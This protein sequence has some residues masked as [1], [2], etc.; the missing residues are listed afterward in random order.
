MFLTPKPAFLPEPPQ[1]RPY[2]GAI[3][4]ANLLCLFFHLMNPSPAASEAT[5]GY[6]HGGLAMD[7]IGQKGPTSKLHL[8]ML[9][10]LVLLLQLVALGAHVTRIKVK[11]QATAPP[12]VPAAPQPPMPPV[13][14][15]QDLDHEE[16][17]VH[18]SDHDPVD[19][20]LQNL[21]PSVRQEPPDEPPATSIPDEEGNDE[22]D[23][24]LS[25]STQPSSDAHIF[26]A[27][28]SGEI[29]IADL[30]IINLIHTQMREYRNAPSES[31]ATPPGP[32]LSERL[33]RNGLGLRLRIGN[34]I[35]RV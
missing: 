12:A 20:E 3:F 27:F 4:G 7:F 29:M 24:L 21:N 30:D 17:G 34:R 9:D 15:A 1:N 22:R 18:R 33:S 35:L 2:I 14:P 13:Q 26:D 28:N 31:T 23:T 8:S 5:R 10:M 6:L 19:I 32:G 11:K 16:R 25:S